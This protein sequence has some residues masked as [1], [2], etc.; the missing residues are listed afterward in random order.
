VTTGTVDRIRGGSTCATATQPKF[1]DYCI[2]LCGTPASSGAIKQLV[3]TV[4]G[5][6]YR[7]T[8]WLSGDASAGPAAKR[9]HAKVGSYIDL[10]Y[11]FNCSGTG[12]QNWVVN[13]FEFTARGANEPLEFVADNGVTTGGPMLDSINLGDIT[14]Q[15]V[16]DVDASN[17]V[18]GADLSLL[19][20]NWGDCPA[21]P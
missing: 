14:T 5:H 17:G 16:G 19:L 7:C 11:T 20:L 9:V 18:D 8:F 2:D 4:P 15:C 1:G 12:A 3:P 6:K 21:D 10:T 13:Q